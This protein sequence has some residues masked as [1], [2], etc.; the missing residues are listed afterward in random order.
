MN[1]P[2]VVEP[3]DDYDI[4][5][6]RVSLDVS[7][8]VPVLIFVVGGVREFV[9][10]SWEHEAMSNDDATKKPQRPILDF[11]TAPFHRIALISI[12]ERCSR[13]RIEVSFICKRNMKVCRYDES[14]TIL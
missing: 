7:L 14:F 9:V 12:D 13:F 10:V 3:N 8:R 2:L 4:W 1:L 5:N 6:G 11:M